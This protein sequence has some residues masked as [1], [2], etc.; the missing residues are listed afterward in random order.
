MM[1]LPATPEAVGSFD[2]RHRLKRLDRAIGI[3]LDR[4]IQRDAVSAQSMNPAIACRIR[5]VSA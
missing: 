2:R 3:V 4:A 5:S 1:T